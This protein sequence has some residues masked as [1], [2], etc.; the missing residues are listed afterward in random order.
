ML[1]FSARAF[2]W[3]GSA[4][5]SLQDEALL[6]SMPGTGDEPIFELGRRALDGQIKLKAFRTLRLVIAEFRTIGLD[7]S[8][9]TAED[10]V[11]EIERPSDTH[12]CQWLRDK[13]RDLEKLAEREL[14]G[15]AF[16]YVS[17]DRAKFFPRSDTGFHI[18]GELVAKAF[19][20]A[21]RDVSEA[22]TCLALARGNGCVFHLMRVLEIGLSVLGAVF[23]VSTAHTNWA[24]AIEQIE[25]KIR[26]MHKDAVWKS[27]AD[28]KQQQEFYAQ[29]AAQF[30]V[31][32]D[33]WRNYTMHVRGFYT[34]EEAEQV[35]NSVKA[36]MQ[37]L[38]VK[39]HE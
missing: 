28:Y 9:E 33:A 34:E 26:D 16:F 39:L 19:P 37:K 4:L 27:V 36:F 35:F 13:V 30:G 1:Q 20:S 24:P 38:A 8:A 15:K 6:A 18:F 11:R 29:A 17:A 25:S 12:N 31:L 5:Q 23:G 14:K 22:G 7:I 10:I 21:I 3:C 2:F 32:K